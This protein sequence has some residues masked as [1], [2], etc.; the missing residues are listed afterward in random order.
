MPQ[1]QQLLLWVTARPRGGA[2]ARGVTRRSPNRS[3]SQ[4]LSILGFQTKVQAENSI[5]PAELIELGEATEG[6]CTEHDLEQLRLG[7]L[8]VP[9]ASGD[10]PVNEIATRRSPASVR[11]C[12]KPAI[13]RVL[14]FPGFCAPAHGCVKS[15]PDV[16]LKPRW[17]SRTRRYL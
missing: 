2:S 7:D 5:R 17:Q 16:R 13:G 1:R 4:Q 9:S 14:G 8:L 11:W 10:R 15:G 3:T 12:A 6:R